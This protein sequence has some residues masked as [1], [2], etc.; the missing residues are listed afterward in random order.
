MI[1]VVN[2][3]F[4][5]VSPQSRLLRW[6]WRGP[7]EFKEFE[8][9]LQQLLVISQDHQITQWLVDSSTMPLLGMEEQAWLSDKWLEQFLAL[10]VEHLAFIEPPNLHNQLI[11]ENILSE[12]QRHARIN[13]QFF[14]DIPAALDWLTR[15]ATPLIDSL[16]REWQAAL[17]P[18]QRIYRNAM[19]QLW[20]VGR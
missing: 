12:A 15:S 7:L 4:V 5:Q 11:V 16:E 10:G 18:S 8:Q 20:E 6:E 2:S 19:R 13:F 17:P 1:C 14:S 9:S 3:L